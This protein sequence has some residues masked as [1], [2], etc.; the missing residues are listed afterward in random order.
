[1][2]APSR[3]SPKKFGRGLEHEINMTSSPRPLSYGH[4]FKI[5]E[6]FRTGPDGDADLNER[7]PGRPV[8]LPDRLHLDPFP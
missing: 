5:S 4:V 1:M 7:Q 2:S 3:S 8:G 6:D